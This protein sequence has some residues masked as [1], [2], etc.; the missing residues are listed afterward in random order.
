LQKL[1]VT[2]RIDASM[3]GGGTIYHPMPATPSFRVGIWSDGALELQ[4]N[5]V[6]VASLTQSEQ[7]AVTAFIERIRQPEPA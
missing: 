5:G 2:A 4:R 6:T 1:H 7:E 3:I